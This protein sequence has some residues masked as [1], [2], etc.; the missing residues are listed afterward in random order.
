VDSLAG[1]WWR[2]ADSQRRVFG[3]LSREAEPWT[4]ELEDELVASSA[5][6]AVRVHRADED[7][8]HEDMLH[9]IA[10]GRR[11]TILT[12]ERTSFHSNLSLRTHAETWTLEHYL[13]GVHLPSINTGSN[14]IDVGLGPLAEWAGASRPVPKS[15]DDG[16]TT[17]TVVPTTIASAETPRGRIELVTDYSIYVSNDA[18]VTRHV[19]FRVTPDN[20]L[21]TPDV[22]DRLV[23]PLRDLLA[24]CTT[25]YVEIEPTSLSFITDD[26]A[27]QLAELHS[28]F[29]EPGQKRPTRRHEMMLAF[30]HLHE[31]FEAFINA[32]FRIHDTHGMALTPLLVPTYA[33]FLFANVHLLLAALAV[34]G[35]HHLTFPHVVPSGEHEQRVQRVADAITGDDEL[36]RWAVGALQPRTGKSTTRRLREVLELSGATGAA[37][38]EAV[39]DLVAR[40]NTAR[41]RIAHPSDYATEDGVEMFFVARALRW[42]V[43]HCILLDLGFNQDEVAAIIAGCRLFIGDLDLFRSNLS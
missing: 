3:H 17:I 25:S 1:W 32:W 7:A 4:L 15:R 39:P 36:R 40:A 34:E 13:D 42:I 9:G 37:I 16:G 18:S 10:D 33:P 5:N 8:P 20:P 30:T 6:V 28:P 21:T 12:C 11:M 41:Q 26:G 22:I 23:L 19:S 27:W 31:R 24:L 38:L 2:P 29:L 14:R 35:Y 43:R